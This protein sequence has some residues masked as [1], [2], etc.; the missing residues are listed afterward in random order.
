MKGRYYTEEFHKSLYGIRAL[1][2]D[3]ETEKPTNLLHGI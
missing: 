3:S 1:M 2:P